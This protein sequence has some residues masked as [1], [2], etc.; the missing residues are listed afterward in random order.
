MGSIWLH[1]LDE[2]LD[3]WVG[4]GIVDLV[5]LEGAE[6]RSRSSGGL[7]EFRGWKWHHTA[8]RQRPPYDGA[9]D[10]W[11]NAY[12]N[13]Y[14]P[15]PVA[16]LYLAPNGVFTI[17][18]MGAA[19]H[20]GKGGP[21]PPGDADPVVER[22]RS[23]RTVGGTE[24]GNPGTGSMLWPWRQ[25][26]SSI[27]AA[28]AISVAEGWSPTA[29]EHHAH[30]EYCGPGTSQPGRKIDP[31]GDWEDHPTGLW[32]P[33][34]S[35]GSVQGRIDYWRSLVA[36]QIALISTPPPPLPPPGFGGKPVNPANPTR[37]SQPGDVLQ[38][39]DVMTCIFDPVVGWRPISH[40][41]EDDDARAADKGA[42]DDTFDLVTRAELPAAQLFVS[43]MVAQLDD[44]PLQQLGGATMRDWVWARYWAA[45]DR[46]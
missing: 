3:P 38:L 31:F 46:G 40:A 17:I 8:S 23:N 13:P 41:D 20:G 10:V 24:M 9:S 37:V 45:R 7:D 29:R 34:S 21:W 1:D 11:Y 15:S 27:V 42:N 6:T 16:Q 19:N 43:Q 4:R 32:L 22:D 25:I 5:V 14:A 33:G 28:A 44:T 30:K 36:D 2:V 35:W 12:G 26:Q 18:A 39:Q